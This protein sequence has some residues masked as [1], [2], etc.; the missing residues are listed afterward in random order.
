MSKKIKTTVVTP[1]FNYGKWFPGYLQAIFSQKTQPN[2][3]V[4]VDDCS[5]DD[6]VELIKKELS[7]YEQYTIGSIFPSSVVGDSG[8]IDR[9]PLSKGI[10]FH[11]IQLKQ[12]GGPSRARNFGIKYALDQTDVFCMWDMDDEW[13]PEKISKSI[14]ILDS[15]EHIAV[16][17]TDYDNHN[18][19]KDTL[20]R[21]YKEPYDY[22]RLCQE[23]IVGS[24]AV[25]AASA[26]KGVGIYDEELRVAE[27]YDLWLRISEGKMIYHIPEALYKY[28]VTGEGASFSVDKQVWQQCWKRVHEKRI[29]RRGG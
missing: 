23:C 3:V 2:H 18:T 14:K 19:T 27:D 4:I 17:C 11:I 22:G 28:R 20:E 1:C 13:Y 29:E 16:V 6:S 8:T 10:N 5:T 12:N 25:I 21:E 15:Y 26:F 9:Y 24:N 7:K